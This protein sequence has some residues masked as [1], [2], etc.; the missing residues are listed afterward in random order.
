SRFLS[1]MVQ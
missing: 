1:V